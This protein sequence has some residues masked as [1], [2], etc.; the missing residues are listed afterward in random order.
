MA[1]M[2]V[3]TYNWP[4]ED[5]P[6]HLRGDYDAIRWLNENVQGTAVLAEAPLGYYR[7]FGVR[8]S[9]YTGLPTLLGMHVREQRY[10]W[11]ESERGRLANTFFVTADLQETMDIARELGIE[12]V[13]IGPLERTQYPRAAAKFDQ[14]AQ[15]A[16]LSVVYWNDQVTIYRVE[17]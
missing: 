4:N 12:Y 13:Y 15:R 5:N 10:G 1:F 6:I 9:S 2:T 8:V 3:G 14:L 11:Q 7:E 16:L 17:G